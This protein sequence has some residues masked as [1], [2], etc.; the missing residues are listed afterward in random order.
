[1]QDSPLF[2]HLVMVIFFVT[3]LLLITKCQEEKFFRD[4]SKFEPRHAFFR[5][6]VSIHFMLCFLRIKKSS[7]PW[8]CLIISDP[9]ALTWEKEK[10]ILCCKIRACLE[11][12]VFYYKGTE[13][14]KNELAIKLCEILINYPPLAQTALPCSKSTLN[15]THLISWPAFQQN[16]MRFFL[17]LQK[18]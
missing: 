9:N 16:F 12:K 17:F 5:E 8:S 14:R 6:M 10:K 4:C 15:Y 3:K 2:N 1:M 11:K 13:G 18:I 7:F